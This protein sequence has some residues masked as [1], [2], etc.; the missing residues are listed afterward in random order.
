ML[1][2]LCLVALAYGMPLEEPIEYGIDEDLFINSSYIVAG[3]KANSCEF[4]SIVS[5]QIQK[6]GKTFLCGGSIMDATH[7]ITAAHCVF[8]GVTRIVVFYGA[9]STAQA[10]YTYATRIKAH[11]G[12]YTTSRALHN[13]VAIL[14]LG[15]A[16]QMSSCVKAI[17]LASKH[18][19]FDGKTCITAGWGKLSCNVLKRLSTLFHDEKAT[20]NYILYLQGDSGGPLYCQSNG[21]QVLAGLVSFGLKCEYGPAMY[22]SVSYFRSWIDANKV[23]F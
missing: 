9:T 22:T 21:R 4:P 10:K 13:D 23:N 1:F 18:T 20:H 8:S 6:N 5:L 7:V 3:Q 19:V 15:K 12:F 16:I 17:P 11:S 2:I 14:T